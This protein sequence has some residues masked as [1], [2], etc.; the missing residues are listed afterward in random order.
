MTFL[1]LTD[2]SQ[3]TSDSQYL[4][5]LATS[6]RVPGS[7]PGGYLEYFYPQGEIISAVTRDQQ[8][9]RLVTPNL[10]SRALQT[11][12]GLHWFVL[13]QGNRDITIYMER[14][15]PGLDCNGLALSTKKQKCISSSR[16]E[17]MS[18]DELVQMFHK[19]AVPLPQRQYRDNRRGKLL[20][21]MRIKLERKRRP[22]E[23]PD[24][25][26]LVSVGFNVT[27]SS[28]QNSSTMQD[29]LKPPPVAINF[30][31]KKIRL[32]S[33]S[34]GSGNELNS[35]QIKN[36]KT[37]HISEKLFN[38]DSLDNVVIN[39]RPKEKG[40]KA[41]ETK[42]EN[43]EANKIELRRSSELSSCDT[44]KSLR[45]IK[46]KRPHSTNSVKSEVSDTR[47][48]QIT[49]INSTQRSD[50]ILAQDAEP[51]GKKQK[52]KITWP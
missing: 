39:Y 6:P 12:S 47:P 33:V 31:R 16:L 29:R 48:T 49:E 45:K 9:V 8:L 37:L 26:S 21:R 18:K 32:N 2:S 30:E 24:T 20:T 41:S 25:S 15:R 44:K 28:R 38:G 46:L 19:F 34:S 43:G 17:R 3:L 10:R 4:A 5:H 11:M 51:R 50:V 36:F 27:S 52:S 1:V 23:Q 35:P 14:S 40:H 7:I 42:E 22:V 13:S